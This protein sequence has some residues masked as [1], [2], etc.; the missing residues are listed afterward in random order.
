MVIGAGSLKCAAAYGVARVLQNHRIPIARIIGCS[1]GAFCAAWLAAG[2]GD[3]QAVAERFARGWGGAFDEVD[4]GAILASV[5]PRWLGFTP[6]R[7]IVRDRAINAAIAAE[8]GQL[9]FEDLDTP[10]QLVA[11]DFET[12]EQIVISSGRL[13]D[14]IRAS[15]A[16]PLILPPWPQG[17]RM[18]VDG[19]VCDPLPVDVAVREG[20]DI[21][22]AVGF[23]NP[24][25]LQFHSGM[26]LVRQVTSLM[27]N[28]LLRAQ[29]AFFNLAHDAETVLVMPEF[30]RPVGLGDVH[31]VPWL[32]EQGALAAEREMPYLRRLLEAAPLRAA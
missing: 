14:A 26:G 18:L 15:I 8:F 6:K 27:V 17:G 5:F 2:G 32:V 24:L 23:E 22:V 3:A 4:Y 21:I 11:T 19:A 13:F 29:Y 28:Q 10:L 7:G 31:L 9:R 16:L 1:G 20:A 12:G 25:E 30:D